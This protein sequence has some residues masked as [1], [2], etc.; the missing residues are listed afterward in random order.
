[1][2]ILEKYILGGIPMIAD[3]MMTF[4]KSDINSFW[5]RSSFI[6]YCYSYGLFLEN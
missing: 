5:F 1:M 6:Y 2:K 4:I 3:D